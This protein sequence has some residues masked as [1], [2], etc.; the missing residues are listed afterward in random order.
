[1]ITPLHRMTASDQVASHLR[2]R[3]LRGNLAGP[4]PGVMALSRDCDASPVTVR[5]ALRQLEAE[6]WIRSAG[7]GK[8][9]TTAT[10]SSGASRPNSRSLRIMVLP[11]ERVEDEDGV[12]QQTLIQL[13]NR[14]EADGHTLSFAPKSQSRLHYDL[15]RVRRLVSSCEADAWI[16]IGGSRDVLTWFAEHGTPALALG[17]LS[18][19]L[20][21]S[22]TGMETVQPF[23]NAVERLTSLGHR[24]IIFIAPAVL[25]DAA[26]SPCTAVLHRELAACGVT[27]GEYHTPA[28]DETPAGL[29]ALLTANF[30]LTPPTAII[31]TYTTWLV[32]LLSFMAVRN[33]QVAHDVSVLCLGRDFWLPWHQPTIAHFAGDDSRM[34]QHILRWANHI[35]RG[36]EDTRQVRFPLEFI[37]G[38]SFGPP[39]TR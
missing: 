1:M 37:E 5:A 4:I 20:P 16:V 39:R 28:F 36:Q 18:S 21:L 7:P 38:E 23:R 30:R 19:G 3:I 27:A 9:R 8:P 31:V 29:H 26:T 6:G 2:D 32:S 10:P 14:I 11:G 24:R 25:R 34:I 33:L 15:D 13:R 22:A 35:A 17:G 12:F